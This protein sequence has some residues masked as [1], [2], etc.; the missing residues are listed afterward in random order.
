MNSPGSTIGFRFLSRKRSL[1]GVTVN[2]TVLVSPG[3]RD[4]LAKSFSSFTARRGIYPTFLFNH[5]LSRLRFELY[6]GSTTA[7]DIFVD[8][9]KV[10]SRTR[11]VFT[12][13]HKSPQNMGIDFSGDRERKPLSLAEKDGSRLR[14]ETY[15]TDATAEIKQVKI[16]GSLLLAP[17]EEYE[18]HLFLSKTV[19]DG[20]KRKYEN[21]FTVRSSEGRF[22]PGKQYSVRLTIYG[23]MS[24]LP[25]VSIEP[26]GYGGDIIIDDDIWRPPESTGKPTVK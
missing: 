19:S 26:W 18:V 24:V 21:V 25:N 17:D 16:G 2:S 7:D 3:S 13:A 9:I 1:S 20:R 4:I 11:G 12:V 23:P 6:P 22:S 5:H 15:H 10:M 14:T 8:S